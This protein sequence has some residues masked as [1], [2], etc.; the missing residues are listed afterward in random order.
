VETADRTPVVLCVD[1]EASIRNALRRVFLD[2][3][4]DLHFADGG[5]AGLDVIR[6]REVDLV[7]SDFRMPGM[8]GV[9]FL[10]QAK[11]IQPD[12]VRIVLSGYAD[13]KLIVSA[14]NEGEVYRFIA[15]P[16]NDGELQHNIRN[17]LEHQR[18]DRENRHLAAELR[19]LN[20]ELER[21]VEERTGELV[22]KNRALGFA[23]V[24]LELLPMPVLAVNASRVVVFANAKA[25]ELLA[26]EAG[27][28][29]GGA[30]PAIFEPELSAAVARASGGR[31]PS[32]EGADR[33]LPM[34]LDGE[35]VGA[36]IL[37]HDEDPLDRELIDPR[38]AFGW[39]VTPI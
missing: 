31:T 23:R 29:V 6:E 32:R 11:E 27:D 22:E 20:A 10:K 24:V 17:A 28:M 12:C 7:L 1:D 34:V 39:S 3:G 9:E 30:A 4:W 38:K 26:G 21:K 35:P 2:D 25:R 8:D 19:R 15:K 16:W 5:E 33:V 14:L 13:I 36:I 18:A 37:I